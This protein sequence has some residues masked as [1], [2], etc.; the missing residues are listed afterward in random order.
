AGQVEVR[1]DGQT[2]EAAAITYD[3]RNE[4]VQA[5]GPLRLITDEGVVLLA[6]MAELTPDLRDGLVTG[7][8]LILNE[9]LQIAAAGGQRIAG[10]YNGLDRIVATSC[11]VCATQPIPLWQIRAERVIHDEVEER[12]W[13]RNARFDVLGIPIA[14]TPILRIPAPG[15]RRATG[16]LLP[17]FS[18]S[19]IYGYGVKLPYFV[20]LG[21]HADLT[22]TA[23]LTTDAGAILETEYRQNFRAGA[24]RAFAAGALDDAEDGFARGFVDAAAA[25]ALPQGFRLEGA[26]NVVSD[27]RFLQEF[28]YSD[29]DRLTSFVSVNRYRPRTL[30]DARIIGYQSL[31]EDETEDEI[32]LVLPRIDYRQI[33]WAGPMN[34][35]LGVDADAL[36]LV[37][38]DGRD[39]LRAGA[40]ANWRGT[41]TLPFG[42]QAA[43]IGDLRFDVYAPSDDPNVA[44]DLATRFVPTAGLELRWPLAR[45]TT[46]AT[47]VVEPIAQVFWSEAFQQG[48]IVNED[49]LLPELDE[50][51]LFLQNRFPGRDA[52]E[53]GARANLGVTYTRYDPKGWT[54]AATAGQVFRQEAGDRFTL[55]SGLTG[56]TSDL[57][58]ALTFDLPP[59]LEVTGRTLL[60][61]DD[62]T[63]RRGELEIAYVSTPFDLATGYVYLAEDVEAGDLPER[64]EYTLSGRWRFAPNWELEGGLRIDLTDGTFL[65]REAQLTYGNECVQLAL[66]LSRNVTTS[67]TVPT[68]TNIGLSVNLAG[69]GGTANRKWPARRCNTRS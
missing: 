35:R 8:R 63:F 3:R 38:P 4:R 46:S 67:T 55:G 17:Q 11:V 12:I 56:T 42:V 53:T 1:Y 26:L 33:W 58:A 27:D 47:H 24:L 49:S 59:S 44:D 28:N 10:R 51:S 32:P 2:L 15:V 30:F 69:L 65:E 23:F 21:D 7:A 16:A 5:T 54:M 66:S 45:Q 43:L 14:Y 48:E 18:S 64:Q 40:G 62:F 13:F 61:P 52:V 6:S 39:V 22:L 60:A 19:G 68:T 9:E 57:V 41:P 37:R 31:R 36:S 20:T 29:R 34:G 50:T 25:F